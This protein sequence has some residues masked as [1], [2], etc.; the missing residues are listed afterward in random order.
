MAL[1]QI[2]TK[3]YSRR[4]LRQSDV[5]HAERT[6]D[7]V[8]HGEAR[9]PSRTSATA[10]KWGTASFKR[11]CNATRVS[12][13]R[14]LSPVHNRD[15][16][17]LF[18][19]DDD[20]GAKKLKKENIRQKT[21]VSATAKRSA[22]SMDTERHMAR[23]KS[24]SELTS[25]TE[26]SC[27]DVQHDIKRRAEKMTRFRT[28]VKAKLKSVECADGE[29]NGLST[30]R[31]AAVKMSDRGDSLELNE[32]NC[33]SNGVDSVTDSHDKK[34]CGRAAGRNTR[35]SASPCK[36]TQQLKVFVDNFQ[37]L[38]SSQCSPSAERRCQRDT[39]IGSSKMS[40]AGQLTSPATKSKSAENCY[41]DSSHSPSSASH[42]QCA[43]TASASS[44]P[45]SLHHRKHLHQNSNDDNDDDDNED[46]ILLSPQPRKP[47]GKTIS[48]N[49]SLHS[50]SSKS[51]STP[52]TR[53]GRSPNSLSLKSV[54]C[55]GSNK[56]ELVCDKSVQ[57][58]LH[59]MRTSDEH[60]TAAT[61]TTAAAVTTATAS[62][63]RLL[64]GSR[65]VSYHLLQYT[66][67]IYRRVIIYKV[68]ACCSC[69]LW[70][71]GCDLTV[72]LPAEH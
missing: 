15:D 18:D 65:R 59:R 70:V 6:F 29:Q 52:N 13:K 3:T 56:N 44:L 37:L 55:S 66:F 72:F 71:T 4:R 35:S 50:S 61:T 17:F 24:R 63:R 11:I 21:A 22:D 43:S 54:S 23:E 16:P 20:N 69:I 46:V 45:S 58:R 27:A 10:E 40:S 49:C 67:S 57:L 68:A 8:F 39:S 2:V 25:Y 51:S 60:A 28:A 5:S 9:P 14:R 1:P 30:Y 42:H 48:G 41:S 31:L 33:Q 64:T 62:T 36:T 32:Q 47:A 26:K 34:P 7:E 38:F 12:P 19:S 53:S